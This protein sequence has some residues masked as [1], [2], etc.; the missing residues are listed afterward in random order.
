MRKRVCFVSIIIWLLASA[1]AGC[2]VNRGSDGVWGEAGE[3]KIRIVCTIFPQYDWVRNIIKGNE[4]RFLLTLLMDN[5]GD[6]HSFQPSALDIARISSCDLFI[7]VGGESDGWVEDVLKEAENPDMRAINMME[8]VETGLIEEEPVEGNAAYGHEGHGHE[9]AEHAYDEHVWLSLR[10]AEI[11]AEGICAQLEELDDT[12]SN[13]YR[14]NCEDYTDKLRALDAK[15]LQTV[16]DGNTDTLLFADRFPFRYLAEDYG[17]EY[18]A[19]FDGCSAETEASFETVAFLAEK[20]DELE[21]GCVLVTDGSDSRLAQV[22]IENTRLGTQQI[23]ELD[24]L[25]S[26]SGK[27]IDNGLSYL[28]AMEA[29]L[30]TLNYALN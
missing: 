6:L 10:N 29:N 20:L 4:D 27:E 23:A 25:Q 30:Q 24:S 12:G 17:L 8:A 15:Y 18:Y 13:L 2:A 7:Y 5:G 22:I 26:V 19:A 9:G 28:S 11:L 16:K 3:D 21:L 14:R 1:S